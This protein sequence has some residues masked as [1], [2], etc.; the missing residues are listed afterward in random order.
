MAKAKACAMLVTQLFY[1]DGGIG[2]ACL[3]AE[4]RFSHLFSGSE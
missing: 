1:V 3:L 2:G 4:S